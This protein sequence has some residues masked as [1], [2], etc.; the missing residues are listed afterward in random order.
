MAPFIYNCISLLPYT[1]NSLNELLFT[2]FTFSFSLFSL[3]WTLSNRTFF[4]T[5]TQKLV[6]TRSLMISILLNHCSHPSFFN[7]SA[8]FDPVNYFLK[9]FL[10]LLL[11][12]LILQY[13]RFL[14]SSLSPFP[15]L[16]LPTAGILLGFFSSL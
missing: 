2:Y 3:I 9:Y 10:L 7:L 16:V 14:S 15:V 13:L 5:T 11:I 12:L 8:S 6:L 4:Y 1:K